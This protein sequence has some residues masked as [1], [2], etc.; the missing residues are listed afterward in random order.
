MVVGGFLDGLNDRA[1]ALGLKKG[2]ADGEDVCTSLGASSGVVLADTAVHTDVEVKTLLEGGTAQDANLV[3]HFGHERLTAKTGLNRHDQNEIYRA[4]VGK[5][6][7]CRGLGR[8][9][10]TAGDI[11]FLDGANGLGGIRYTLKVEGQTIRSCLNE[12]IQSIWPMFQ[13]LKIFIRLLP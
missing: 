9:G 8:D 2:R 1:G 7:L 13:K 3:Q 4:D 12:G 10:D 5:H 11:P 6:G